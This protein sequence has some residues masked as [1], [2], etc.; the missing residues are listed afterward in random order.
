MDKEKLNT[1]PAAKDV[2]NQ[3]PYIFKK[4]SKLSPNSYILEEKSLTVQGP[5]LQECKKI[6]D[7]KWK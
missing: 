4:E 1:V 3:L 6:F 7:E 5:D 2:S